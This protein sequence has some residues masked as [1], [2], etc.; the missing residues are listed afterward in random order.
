[1]KEDFDRRLAELSYECNRRVT[2]LSADYDKLVALVQP[3]L[4]QSIR[5]EA[6]VA[7]LRD[8]PG[9]ARPQ[10]P[11]LL[12]SLSAAALSQLRVATANGG[13]PQAT[14]AQQAVLLSEAAS[15]SN[16]RQREELDGM[17]AGSRPRFE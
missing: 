13:M 15:S 7:S 2:A 6:A 17:S 11:D 10:M 9:A 8:F 1:M 12:H 14:A 5:N 3:L 16:K 4:Q